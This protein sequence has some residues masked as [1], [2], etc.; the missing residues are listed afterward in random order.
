MKEMDNMG[1]RRFERTDFKVKGFI[2]C[3]KEECPVSVINI[4]MKGILVTPDH[5]AIPEIGHTYPLRIS[6]PHSDI[7][8]ITEA[9][10]MHE[11]DGHFGFRFDSIEADGMIHLRRLLELNLSSEEEIERELSFLKK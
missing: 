1:N 11:E 7:S 9:R 10:L 6:L 8:I 4:S 3:G 2:T 5:E